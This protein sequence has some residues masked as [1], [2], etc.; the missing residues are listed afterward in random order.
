LRVA[1]DV[2][3]E[4]EMANVGKTAA[5]LLKIE[6]IVQEGLELVRDKIDERIEDGYIDMRGRRV[7]HL[8]TYEVKVAIRAKAQ[9]AYQIQPRVLYVDEKGDYRSFE[10]EPSRILVREVEGEAFVETERRLSAIMFTDIVGYTSLTEQNESLALELLG[11]HRRILRPLFPRYSGREV[12]TVG[13]MF[14]VEFASALEAVRCASRI[15]E[16]LSKRNLE[17]P[18]DRKVQIRIGIH[19]GDVEHNRGD[20]YGEAVNTASRIEPLAQPGGIVVTR[21]VYDQI[22]NRPGIKMESMGN[23]KLKNVKES[24][25]VFKISL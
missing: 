24:L 23:Q 5:T 9:G 22:R 20:V 4:L 19:V 8:K 16:T 2:I 15:Q 14:L 25:E 6:N 13:D 11:E 17:C 7:D 21:Q 10:F 12:K 1:S 3:L 18:E